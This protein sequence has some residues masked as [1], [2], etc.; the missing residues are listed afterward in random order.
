[1]DY[2]ECSKE[3]MRQELQRRGLTPQGNCDQLSEDLQ[4][5]DD[6]RGSEATTIITEAH[7]AVELHDT[8]LKQPTG[9]GKTVPAEDLVNQSAHKLCMHK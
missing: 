9:S 2:Y 8:D 5:D 1:M 6:A 4:A 7:M 3:A